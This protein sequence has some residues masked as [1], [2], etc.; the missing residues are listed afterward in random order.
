M[1]SRGSPAP[2]AMARRIFEYRSFP[3]TP[4]ETVTKIEALIAEGKSERHFRGWLNERGG[5]Y[6]R[7]YA[8]LLFLAIYLA[9]DPKRPIGTWVEGSPIFWRLECK[10]R[11]CADHCALDGLVR[12]ASDPVWRDFYP[13][14]GW[15]C[16][17]QII[18]VEGDDIAKSPQPELTVRMAIAC[19]NWFDR[20][21]E[22]FV[23]Q[24]WR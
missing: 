22:E 14:N 2:I 10:S 7:R 5:R 8:E 13:P 20:D 21:L 9:R 24:N 23:N 15:C 4:E 1:N 12:D 3:V 16:G 17:C 11:Y 19:S 6:D 18:V